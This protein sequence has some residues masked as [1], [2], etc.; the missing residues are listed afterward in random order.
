MGNKLN[1]KKGENMKDY[2]AF[3]ADLKKPF[4]YMPY[5]C[6]Q[7]QHADC[8]NPCGCCGKEIKQ[9]K[10]YFHLC[11]GGDF[12]CSNADDELVVYQD[13]GDMGCWDIGPEC[14]KKLKVHLKEEGVNPNDYIGTKEVA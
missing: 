10:H 3:K 14:L 7:D 11:D 1:N 5:V 6:D 9:P 2:D 8:D 4:V 13:A 12:I